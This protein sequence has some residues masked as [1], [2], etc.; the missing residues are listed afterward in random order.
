MR[1]T[2]FLHEQRVSGAPTPR[3]IHGIRAYLSVAQ[4][5]LP[6]KVAEDYQVLQRILPGIRGVG[7]RYRRV[8]EDLAGM[9][10]RQSWRLSAQRCELIRARGEELGDFY[11]FFHC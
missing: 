5:L 8:L 2:T 3:S 4:E 7:E 9:C 6:I 1:L 10:G 11:D